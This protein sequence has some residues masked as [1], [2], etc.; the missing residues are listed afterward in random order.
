MEGLAAGASV[1]GVLSLAGQTV[2]GI[3][4]L[5]AFFKDV[6]SASRT[7]DRFLQAINQLIKLISDVKNLLER[8]AESP[9]QIGSDF[10]IAAL[11]IQLEDCSRDVYKWL[12][13]AKDHHPG[14]STGTKAGFKKFWVAVNK[15]EVGCI[16][17][18][19]REHRDGI[20]AS[21][22]V[23]GKSVSLCGWRIVID[24]CVDLWVST[25]PRSFSHFSKPSKWKP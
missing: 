15:G 21:L 12:K 14:F 20:V 8:V 2:E 13:L 22:S 1:T 24:N 19:I 25:N 16:S 11:K 23:L 9:I 6:S 3:V 5:H 17:E 7:I 10:K 18:D 4:K